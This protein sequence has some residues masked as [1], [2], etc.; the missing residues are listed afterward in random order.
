[1]SEASSD[2]P[3]KS[4]A[5]EVAPVATSPT[6]SSRGNIIGQTVAVLLVL[7]G[8]AAAAKYVMSIQRPV[9]KAADSHGPSEKKDGHEAHGDHGDE[10]KVVKLTPAQLRNARLVIET[11]VES[12]IRE[13]VKLNGIIQPNE[14]QVVA[15]LPRFGGIVRAVT[16]RLG[17]SVKIG[18][19][20]ARIESNESLT[21]YQLTAPISGTVIERKGTLGEYADKDKRL[22]VIADLSTL[23][24]DF[25]VYQQDFPKLKLGQTVEITLGDMRKTAPISYISPI[26]MTDTQSMLARVV[27]DNKDGGFRPGLFVVGRALLAEQTV[28]VAVKHAAIQQID[29]KPVVF[30]EGKDGFEAR[31]VE[32]GFKDDDL[33][34]IL[35]GVVAGDKVV[36]GNSFVLKAELGKAE[37]THQH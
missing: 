16:K 21:Q 36:T 25:R 8:G 4:T 24:V 11:V 35:F 2:T 7:A 17:E 15:V 3:G 13:T 9:T 37:A 23:W 10:K 14:E 27:V 31:D 22:M 6:R 32:L 33:V 28:A 5:P 19:V 12:K 30:V 34:E 18:E 29:N 20:V 26:G 1:M